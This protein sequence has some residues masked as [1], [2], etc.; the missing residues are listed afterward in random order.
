MTV[1]DM[2]LAVGAGGRILPGGA[3]GPSGHPSDEGGLRRPRRKH[4]APP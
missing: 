1:I 3:M 4:K 2:V